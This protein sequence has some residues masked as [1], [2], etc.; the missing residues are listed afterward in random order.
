MMGTA[1]AVLPNFD[2]TKLNKRT[3]QGEKCNYESS[4]I[5]SLFLQ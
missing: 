2:F 3:Y 5:A 4:T 1:K